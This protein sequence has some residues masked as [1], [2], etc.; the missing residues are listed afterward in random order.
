MTC[1]ATTLR[2]M[3]ARTPEAAL[4]HGPG[5]APPLQRGSA[6]VV[7]ATGC[8]APGGDRGAAPDGALCLDG[9]DIGGGMR[10]G[11]EGCGSGG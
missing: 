6:I 11:F 9:G 1:P 4:G 3:R 7:Y 2:T 10:A 8:A 5:A